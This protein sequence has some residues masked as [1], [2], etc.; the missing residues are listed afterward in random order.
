MGRRRPHLSRT[1]IAVLV[2][3][4]VWCVIVVALLQL[5][6][7]PSVRGWL[8]RT[9]AAR[10]TAAVGMPVRVEDLRISLYP[11]R[12]ALMGV[13]LGEPGNEVLTARVAETAV[14][15]FDLGDRELVLSFLRLAGVRVAMAVPEEEGERRGWWVRVVVR[16]LELEDV[17]VERLALPDG[18]IV[19]ASGVE[20]R[21]TGTTRRPVSAANVHADS[22]TILVPGLAPVSGA[23]HAWGRLTADGWEIGRARGAG[24]GWRVEGKAAAVGRTVTAEGTVGFDLAAL[25]ATVDAGAGLAGWVEGRFRLTTEPAWRLTMD[26]VAPRLEAAGF[27]VADVRGEVEVSAEGVEGSLQDG[28]FAGGTVEGS[29]RLVGLGPPWRHRVAM[30]GRGVGLGEFL[31]ELGVPDGGL[32]AACDVN[33]ELTWDGEK[34]GSGS[35]TAVANLERASGDIPVAGRVVAKLV[36]PGA[37]RFDARALQVAGGS[38]SWDGTLSLG[39]WVP[40]W[41]VRGEAVP[42]ATVGR[43]LRDWVGSEVFPAELVG[44]TAFDLVLCGPFDRLRVVGDAAVAPVAFGTLDAESLVGHFAVA[45]GV[46]TLEDGVVRVGTGTVTV[47]GHML[48]DEALTLDLRFEGRRVPLSRLA[49]WGGIPAPVEGRVGFVGALTGPLARPRGS[50]GVTLE[51][52][53]VAGVDL[54]AGQGRVSVEDG[55]VRL[56]ALEV[57][58]LAADVEVDFA[59]CQASVVAELKGLALERLSPPLAGLVGGALDCSLRGTFPFESPG[60]RLLMSAPGGASGELELNPQGLRLELE[61]SGAWR[62]AGTL[63]RKGR[64]FEG[65]TTFSVSSWRAVGEQ[66]GAGEVPF[67]GTLRGQGQ[68]SVVPSQ[69]LRVTGTVEEATVVLENGSASLVSPAPFAVT[70]SGVSVGEAV[71]AGPDMAVSLVVRRGPSGELGGRIVGELPAELLALAWPDAHPRGRVQVEAE[72]D[73]TDSSPEIAGTATIRTGALTIPGVPGRVTGIDGRVTIVNGSLQLE[74][75][76]FS[77]AGGHGTCA[78]TVTLLPDVE[79]DLALEVNSVRWPLAEGLT[80][81]LSGSVRLVGPLSALVLSGTGVVDPTYYRENVSL[82]SLVLDALMGVQ[83][84]PAADEA[85]VSLNLAIQVPGTFLVENATARLAFEGDLRVV[86]SS[87]AP[88]VLGELAALPGG[89]LTL[90]GVRYDVDH[91]IVTFADPRSISPYLDVMVRGTVDFWEVTAAVTGTLDRL[92]PTLSSNPPLPDS[93]ILGLMSY[94]GAPARAGVGEGQAVAGG[95]LLEQLTGAVAGRARTLLDL[96]QL[97]IDPA[98]MSQTGDPT[99]RVTV[100]KQLSPD[101]SVTLSTNLAANREE[102][103]VSRWRLGPGVYLEAMRESDGSY[104]M[105]VKWKRRY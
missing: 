98:A 48:V 47:S 92:T 102:V 52:V 66:L 64:G 39:S 10:L 99:A 13:R 30:R 34:I 4:S 32:A 25:D 22:L 100:V 51:G 61:R 55:A 72:L 28:Q 20:G 2:A 83:R 105:E 49:H 60:G 50:V 6:E 74:G 88:G 45:D 7:H 41:Q 70:G 11:P 40:R 46:V 95:L 94:G 29:Y 53:N 73:G 65:T 56:Q 21:W 44:E 67:D 75:V 12:V 54:G 35:G 3:L 8:A 5:L 43:S 76:R 62:V 87:S 57:G 82:Q 33:A 37:I 104:S 79:L 9:A 68:V 77:A 101:W 89:E 91:A 58:P 26:V 16:Q 71:F 31:R 38:V 27:T 86:G 63:A 90:S 103:V 96:D 84:V 24:A 17:E 15:R 18:I 93:D 19:R 1:T 42:I 14:S 69:P 85:P 78:G 81:A 97:R 36:A 59:R 23:V 80:P